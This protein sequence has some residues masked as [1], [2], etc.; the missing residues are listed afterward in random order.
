MS[1]SFTSVTGI[2]NWVH[3]FFL[4]QFIHSVTKPNHWLCDIPIPLGL[5]SSFLKEHVIE[6]LYWLPGPQWHNCIEQALPSSHLNCFWAAS[7]GH[8]LHY[9]QPMLSLCPDLWG[10]LVVDSLQLPHWILQ[11]P[12]HVDTSA[13]SQAVVYDV[14]RDMLY[15]FIFV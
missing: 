6:V 13:V 9:A 3:S 7:R 4:G 1:T 8:H 14:L 12:C 5:V 10:G 11:V 15:K 2:H